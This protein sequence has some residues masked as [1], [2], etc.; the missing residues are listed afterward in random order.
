[1]PNRSL[2]NIYR[3]DSSD[4]IAGF[5]Q[6]KPSYSKDVRPIVT[7]PTT[8]K[9]FLM[10]AQTPSAVAKL[11]MTLGSCYLLAASNLL[12][13]ADT[14][15]TAQAFWQLNL[16]RS[17][18]GMSTYAR[19]AQ[20]DQAA[21]NHATYIQTNNQT[22]HQQQVGLP[23]FTGVNPWDRVIA[24]GY[25]TAY[26][27]ENIS[28]GDANGFDSV[29]LL[30]SAIYHR[31]GFL[32]F[33]RDVVGIGAT[34]QASQL[35]AS[36]YNM[37]NNLLNTAC[38]NAS[39]AIP[40]GTYYTNVCQGG[41]VLPVASY[42][43]AMNTLINA[44]PG[45]VV[46]PPINGYDIPPAFF[47]ESPDPLPDL[48][49]SGYP[50]SVQ[51]NP[52][53]FS[54]V[55]VTR[56]ALFQADSNQEISTRQLNETTDPNKR[57]SNLEYA[58]FPLQRLAW[59]TAY[60]AELEYTANN[61]SQR[62]SWNFV[63]RS[64]NAPVTTI[65]QLNQT[66]NVGNNKAVAVY[67]PAGIGGISYS[68]SAGSKL[69]VKFIDN[70]TLL[71]NYQGKL[72]DQASVTANLGARFKLQISAN[73]T[74]YCPANMTP[75]FYSARSQALDIPYIKVDGQQLYRVQFQQ[76]AI[77]TALVFNLTAFYPLDLAPDCKVAEFD[78][79]SGILNIPQVQVAWNASNKQMFTAKLQLQSQAQKP[80]RF[81]LVNASAR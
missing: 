74:S 47:E 7:M 4:S 46:W 58:L 71:L 40:L 62:F 5:Q 39:S 25:P 43:Q 57:F 8:F 76:E 78:S 68:Y 17:Q 52:N 23:G 41:K 44:N 12:L 1:M 50:V 38:L 6:Q 72:G 70:H 51:F 64:P 15:Q 10:T 34:S 42:D 14:P 59:D 45:L 63:T 28:Y 61:A 55:T 56:F 2:S 80:F 75:A 66:L 18:G 48:S 31:F 21:T 29:D 22:G 13:A 81:Q 67:V 33:A 36:V 79:R 54:K 53:Q 69:A 27:S 32:D 3:T 19:H 11:V 73:N 77:N 16:V 26:V 37:G 35:A 60:R 30:M 9:L 20:L 24:L 65:T 49:V